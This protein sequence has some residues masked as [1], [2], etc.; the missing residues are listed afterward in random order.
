MVSTRTTLTSEPALRISYWKKRNGKE[1]SEQEAKVFLR[2]LRGVQVF[3]HIH[4]TRKKS[5]EG[6]EREYGGRVDLGRRHRILHRIPLGGVDRGQRHRLKRGEG[7]D[8][9]GQGLCLVEPK[10]KRV[11]MGGINRKNVFVDLRLQKILLDG[12]HLLPFNDEGHHLPFNDE[13]HHLLSLDGGHHLP[14]GDLHNHDGINVVLLL[15][16]E[17]E[18]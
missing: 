11:V 3:L 16:V 6:I 15:L 9:D 12:G 2:I 13:G 8:N 5:K 18:V 4:P 14:L 1:K 7:H 17:N 10:V